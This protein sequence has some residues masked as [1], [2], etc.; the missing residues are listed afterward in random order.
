MNWLD[1]SRTFREQGVEESET[2]LL[3]R[4]FF[5]SDQNVDSRDPVQLNLLYVQVRS[6]CLTLN[7]LDGGECTRLA[8]VMKMWSLSK[9]ILSIFTNKW[10]CWA[11]TLLI[12][13]ACKKKKFSLGGLVVLVVVFWSNKMFPCPKTWIVW[14]PEQQLGF[15]HG[16]WFINFFSFLF[17]PFFSK[18]MHYYCK[19]LWLMCLMYYYCSV[20][21]SHKCSHAWIYTRSV[22]HSVFGSSSSF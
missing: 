8:L 11:S 12:K 1:H 3:R 6:A 15:C 18:C 22:T 10:L 7:E 14:K 17:A 13:T 9:G 20:D 16:G 2:L 5:Y 4:K 21:D 19:S